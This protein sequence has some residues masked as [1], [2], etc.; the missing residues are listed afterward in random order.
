MLHSFILIL[1]TCTVETKLRNI[2]ISLCSSGMQIWTGHQ[3]AGEQAQ[4]DS[5]QKEEQDEVV[6]C[7]LILSPKRGMQ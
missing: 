3:A 5:R 2:C 4:G 7:K 6:K 1:V